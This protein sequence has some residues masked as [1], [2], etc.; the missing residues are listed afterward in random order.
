MVGEGGEMGRRI[1]LIVEP[2]ISLWAH[3]GLECSSYMTSRD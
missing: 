1:V 3:V 2:V